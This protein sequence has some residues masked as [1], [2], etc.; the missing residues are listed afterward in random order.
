MWFDTT[1]ISIRNKIQYR[2]LNYFERI[3]RQLQWKMHCQSK[4]VFVNIVLHY[5]RYFKYKQFRSLEKLLVASNFLELHRISASIAH[6][7]IR[8][9]LIPLCLLCQLETLKTRQ[10]KLYF[11]NNVKTIWVLLTCKEKKC[12]KSLKK[13]M[14][15]IHCFDLQ[16][17]LY[18]KFYILH[19]R[20]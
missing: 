15:F 18:H 5:T 11:L 9:I 1:A 10:G 12:F 6:S 16:W 4:S 13:M 3:D 7:P 20:I 14:T 8:V 17:A 19:A 2:E